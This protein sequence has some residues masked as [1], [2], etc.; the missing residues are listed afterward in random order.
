M[1]KPKKNGTRKAMRAAAK[2]TTA[3]VAAAASDASPAPAVDI[4]ML[5]GAV[6]AIDDVLQGLRVNQEHR[7]RIDAVGKAVAP[8]RDALGA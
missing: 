3:P 6:V 1:S 8:I 2:K 7:E 5:A 4:A